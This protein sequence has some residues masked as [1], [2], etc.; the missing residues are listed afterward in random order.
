[1][2]G[3]RNVAA[4]GGVH[5]LRKMA[6]ANPKGIPRSRAPRVTQKEPTIMGKM[7]KDP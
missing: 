2:A 7:P 4:S 1:M 3:L 5:S 6:Q